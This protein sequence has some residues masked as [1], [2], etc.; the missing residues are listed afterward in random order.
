MTNEK[1]YYWHLLRDDM[2][3]PFY[4]YEEP[5]WV[6]GET[7]RLP[8]PNIFSR[9]G[10]IDRKE[11]KLCDHGYHACITPES[12]FDIVTPSSNY[13][14]CKVEIFDALPIESGKTKVVGYGRRLVAA[15]P[16]KT[17]WVEYER[18]TDY[19]NHLFTIHQKTIT[20]F[21]R[22]VETFFADKK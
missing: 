2:T 14:L 6:V 12:I 11:I 22:V 18:T 9:I 21:N 10:F 8:K 4:G 5:A 16:M 13:F 19:R 20:E 17:F 1:I 3:P 7:R 15:E